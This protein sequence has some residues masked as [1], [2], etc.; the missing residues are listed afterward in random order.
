MSGIENRIPSEVEIMEAIK[1]YINPRKMKDLDFIHEE[2]I[3]FQ[4][5]QVYEVCDFTKYHGRAFIENAYLG[6]LKRKPDEL[7][8]HHYLKLLLK[9]KLSKTEILCSIR[10]SKEGRRQGIDILGIKMRAVLALF[11][12]IPIIG[13]LL[14]L[15]SILVVLPKLPTRID[16]VDAYVDKKYD[17]LLKHDILLQNALGSKSDRLELETKADCARVD[18]LEMQFEKKFSQK[19]GFADVEELNKSLERKIERKADISKLRELQTSLE[20]RIEEKAAYFET[21]GITDLP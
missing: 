11:Y 13:Y 19:A 3:P 7:G 12:R 1:K 2:V 18:L 15:T 21:E 10:F 20:T 14:K 4:E 6:V 17:Q 9:G 8:F 16:E 5:K